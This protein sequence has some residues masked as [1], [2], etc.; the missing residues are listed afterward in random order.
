M[1]TVSALI[2]AEPQRIFDVLA[3]GWLYP[4]WVVGASRMR[5]VDD[6][7]PAEGA[8]LHHSVGNWPVLI[9]DST[10]MLEW[11]PPRRAVL[12][13][14]GWPAGEARVEL[15]VRPCAE[16]CEV[17]I[18]EDATSGPGRFVP[19]PIRTLAL[20]LRN[21]ETL[22]RLAWLAEGGAA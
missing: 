11:E 12:Q 2:R 5:S 9:D 7:W 1:S 8:K 20:T 15:E 14:R 19:K 17:S 10:S 3:D 13:A 21:T 16:G 6:A 18:R 22:K 4:A